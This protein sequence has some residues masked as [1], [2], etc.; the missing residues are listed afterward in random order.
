M[1]LLRTSLLLLIAVHVGTP[2]I[3]LNQPPA[4]TE[5]SNGVL[6]L[7]LYLPDV[8][9]GFYRGTRFDYSGV[10][11]SL[12]Y[13][14]HNY[15]GPWFG[16]TDPKIV[17]FVFDTSGII[18]GPCSAI[19]GPVEEFS[20]QGKALSFEERKPGNLYQDRSRSAQEA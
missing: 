6:H 1:A 7:G 9:K 10:I 18:A 3:R 11:R 14:G 8:N 17:D 19:T 12:E 5:I 13:N 15:Y 4:E 2:A 20:C 16:K